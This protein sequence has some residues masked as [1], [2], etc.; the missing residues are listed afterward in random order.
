MDSAKVTRLDKPFEIRP[1]TKKQLAAH[2][3][4]SLHIL[5]TWLGTIKA[6]LGLK[7][8]RTYHVAQ[9]KTIIEAFGVPGQS[10]NNAA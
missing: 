8:G 10:V 1:Y 6:K 2:Y 4:V 9:V 7:I 3:G 5:N